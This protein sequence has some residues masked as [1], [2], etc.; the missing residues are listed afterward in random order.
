VKKLRV[1]KVLWCW[2]HDNDIL[3]NGFDDSLGPTLSRKHLD[4]G[5]QFDYITIVRQF[6]SDCETARKSFDRN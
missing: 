1:L 3:C 4:L 5:S 6:H 2:S